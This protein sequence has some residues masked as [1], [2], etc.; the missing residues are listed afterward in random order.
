MIV[1]LSR[2]AAISFA[3]IRVTCRCDHTR[4]H[5][6]A[7]RPWAIRLLHS[8]NIQGRC[9]GRAGGA[10]RT[11]HTKP[12]RSLKSSSS[13]GSATTVIQDDSFATFS[14]R[15]TRPE[16]FGVQRATIGFG[17][18]L[19]PPGVE[20]VRET[21]VDVL[22]WLHCDAGCSHVHVPARPPTSAQEE[23][24]LRHCSDA[25]FL[26]NLCV[27]QESWWRRDRGKMPRF[28]ERCQQLTAARAENSWLR[29]GS[30]TVQQQALRD[31]DQAMRNFFGGTHRRPTWR[32]AKQHEGFG[33]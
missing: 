10:G 22:H 7:K 27:E 19:V 30:Q 21:D 16:D 14:P 32:K 2:S 18:F 3:T 11:G 31:F 25:R 26:W 15:S 12:S 24:L 13:V 4:V 20:V 1:L 29:S 17:C 33:S 8:R 5:G 9:S 28:A 6:H 23:I